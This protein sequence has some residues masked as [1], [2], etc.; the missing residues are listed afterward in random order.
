MPV[1]AP[2]PP[3]MPPLR[4]SWSGMANR[5][6]FTQLT[7]ANLQWGALRVSAAGVFVS[8][9]ITNARQI[10]ISGGFTGKRGSD[11]LVGESLSFDVDKQQLHGENVSIRHD[12]FRLDAKTFTRGPLGLSLNNVFI[13]DNVPDANRTLAISASNLSFV[14]TSGQWN[15]QNLGL[16]L[17]KTHILTV[18]SVRFQTG[19]TASASHATRFQL[20]LSFRQSGISGPVAT[21]AYALQPA[22]GFGAAA[23]FEQTAKRGDAASVAISY[24]LANQRKRQN[25]DSVNGS[26]A[27]PF[28]D[29]ASILSE[30]PA[31]KRDVTPRLQLPAVL[32]S[33]LG[34][35][36]ASAVSLAIADRQEVIRRYKT[37]LVDHKP[38]AA[39]SSSWVFGATAIEAHYESGNRLETDLKTATE[40]Y[41]S[42]ASVRV[43]TSGMYAKQ[44]IPIEVQTVRVAAVEKYEYTQVAA[45][46]FPRRSGNAFSASMA[47]RD[48]RGNATFYSD[49]LE[50]PSELQLR[51]SL[52]IAGWQVAVGSRLDLTSDRFFDTEIVLAAPGRVIRPEF[53]YRTRGNQFGLNIAMPFFS[54]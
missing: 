52:P 14:T 17:Y 47:V 39:V 29:V 1:V 53:R 44:R 20:P 42:K 15:I 2:P 13:V 35:T 37:V 32:G 38:L 50:A 21:V 28:G 40:S 46:L 25:S 34:P 11:N 3:A 30:P 26:E 36:G 8:P 24:E 23:V 16:A 48:I 41:R 43:R 33:A 54:L 51:Y 31:V 5:D 4:A 7:D 19:S 45:E 22:K 27:L 49:V 18:P 6:G 10:R 12:V 9:S